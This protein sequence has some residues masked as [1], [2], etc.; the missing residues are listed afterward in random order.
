M[1]S[2]QAQK[3]IELLKD[4][5]LSNYICAIIVGIGML[6]WIAL[7]IWEIWRLKKV[8]EI[9]NEFIAGL[10]EEQKEAVRKYKEIIKWAS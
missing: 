6:M 3:I 4:F 9:R 10:T 2:D 1:T 5:E 8:K 7:L